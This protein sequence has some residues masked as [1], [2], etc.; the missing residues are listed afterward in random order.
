MEVVLMGAVA[1]RVRERTEFLRS[2][3]ARR[4]PGEGRR[5]CCSR[6]RR[7]G[8]SQLLQQHAQ[9]PTANG[10]PHISRSQKSAE[11]RKLALP[12]CIQMDA[13]LRRSTIVLQLGSRAPP[14]GEY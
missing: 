10:A 14:I 5:E 4:K 9:P 8:T 13:A 2:P 6:R 1:R 3:G 7:R 12:N 11:M